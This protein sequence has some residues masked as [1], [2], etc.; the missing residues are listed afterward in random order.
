LECIFSRNSIFSKDFTHTLNV[1][2]TFLLTTK[3]DSHATWSREWRSPMNGEDNSV[4][5]D[6]MSKCFEQ[7]M[8]SQQRQLQYHGI[9]THIEHDQWVAHRREHFRIRVCKRKKCKRKTRKNCRRNAGKDSPFADTF[10]QII[11]LIVDSHWFVLSFCSTLTLPR[12]R[13]EEIN[14]G[15]EKKREK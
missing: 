5:W 6:V 11:S 7:L 9:P 3:I 2:S 14:R 13:E 4:V 10:F 15:R 12:E 8:S 1:S